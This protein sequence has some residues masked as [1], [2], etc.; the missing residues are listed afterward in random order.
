MKFQVST[1]TCTRQA[2]C[3]LVISLIITQLQTVSPCGALAPE[4]CKCCPPMGFL[5]VN[6]LK[7]DILIWYL[8]SA[9]IP[10]SRYLE[11]S[12]IQ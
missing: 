10:E 3:I 5:A 9:Q 8:V 4:E 2:N 1:D 11:L 12:A 7:T 6:V